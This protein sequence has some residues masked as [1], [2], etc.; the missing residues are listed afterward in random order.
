MLSDNI[1]IL[2]L[3]VFF[4]VIIYI[5]FISNNLESTFLNDIA[6]NSTVQQEGFEAGSSVKNIVEH[7]ESVV[8]KLDD[9][10]RVTKYRQDYEELIDNAEELY[11]LCRVKSLT[12]LNNVNAND[13]SSAVPIAKQLY[14]FNGTIESI[15]NCKNYVDGK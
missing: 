4:I 7:V 1:K 2:L 5:Y 3:F 10:L 15:E 6:N 8:N 13:I 14:Y 11:E 12:N 9:E